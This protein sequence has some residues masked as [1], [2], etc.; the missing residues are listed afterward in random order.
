MPGCCLA[1]TRATGLYSDTAG[2]TP[3]M[4]PGTAVARL[5]SQASRTVVLTQSTPAN[6]PLWGRYPV[7]GIRNLLVQSETFTGDRWQQI[8]NS[9]VARWHF[10]SRW[11]Q[12]R[13]S[14][15]QNRD[16]CHHTGAVDC[17]WRQRLCHVGA[18]Q[19]RHFQFFCGCAATTPRRSVPPI[20]I[21]PAAPSPPPRAAP[22]RSP[23]LATVG[24]AAH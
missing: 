2:L 19:S 3:V 20:S 23:V 22:H 18:C 8:D 7:T 15:D 5:E 13:A 4:A 12:R 9:P 11:R 17:P 24:G 6:R 10:G 14:A 16:R 1:A 21:W